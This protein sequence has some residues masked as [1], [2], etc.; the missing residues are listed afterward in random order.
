MPDTT[1]PE[2]APE[3]ARRPVQIDPQAP[4]TLDDVAR[5]A[6]V[7]R[8]AASRAMNNTRHVSA[9]K[10]EAVEQAARELGYV[11]NATARALATSRAGSVVLAVVNENPEFLGDP[12]FSQV[13]VGVATAL[14]RSEIDLTLM[15]AS[16]PT[17]RARLERLLRSRRSDGVMLMA[18]RGDD[19][20]NQVV[21]T[22]SL[23]VV[24]CGRPMNGEP[25]WYVDADNRGGA[26][27]G[28]EHLVATG[29]RRIATITG[30]MDLEAAVARYRGFTDA[31]AVAGLR[32]DRV[33]HADFT[34]TGGFQAMTAL[35][36]AHP[37]LDAVFVASDNMAAGAVRALQA[38]G[39]S[40]P[41]DVA[42][43]GFDDLAIAQQTAPAL[44][45]ISQPIHALGHEMATM[46]LRLMD[47]E[48]PSPIILPTRLVVRGSA[49]GV[50]DA[51][52]SGPTYGRKEPR[53]DRAAPPTEH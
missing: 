37:D 12:L 18:L 17:S 13:M 11:P 25:R 26:R 22:T 43:V 35:L 51:G 41:E 3:S 19:P 20:L 38:N 14:E 50:P 6:G 33:A 23:P 27:Q 36:A 44:T 48:S 40:V 21:E 15:L 42:V 46:L 52:L 4:P 29:R 24:F 16:S 30:P 32:G 45:T 5:R 49:P 39:R 31:M 28:A 1:G 8:S 9:A 7:S 34:D 10:R 53:D 47:G 2:R